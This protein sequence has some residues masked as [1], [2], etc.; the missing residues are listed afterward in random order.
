MTR[1]QATVRYQV[2]SAALAVFAACFPVPAA[3]Q[4][5]LDPT[6]FIVVG[7]GLGAGMADFALREVYQD[8]SFGAQMARQMKTAFPQPLIQSPGIGMTPGFNTLPV[9]LPGVLQGSVRSQFPPQLFVFNLSVP[10]MRLSDSLTRRPVPPV[11]QKDVFQTTLNMTLGY[12]ALIAGVNK[13]LWTQAEYAVKMN[14]SLVVVELG[15]Y[16]VLEP[17]I[18]N[19]PALLP[20]VATFRNNVTTL[21]GRLQFSSP[22]IV[23]MTIPDPFDTAYFANLAGVT[24]LTGVPASALMNIFNL[25]ADDLVTPSGIMAISNATVA[26]NTRNF[27][28]TQFTSLAASY[29]GSVVSAATRAA[30]Q[31]RLAALNT[32]LTTGASNVKAK[33]YDLAALYRGLRATGTLIGTKRITSDYLGGFFSLNGYYP[34]TTGHAMIANE[35][36][37]FLNKSYGT[38]FT[39]LDLTKI[40][41]DDPAVR[42]MPALQ[43]STE[44]IQ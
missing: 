12:P 38:S 37:S 44:D 43:I 36:L 19:D 39:L 41:P 34:G 13:P 10:G 3:A 40:L 4:T 15:F 33:V 30:V 5:K 23:V 26:T 2:F 20:D 24:R 31:A 42:F 32:E 7:E 22:E 6:Q 16:E 8:K 21:L 18:Q 28:G 27:L 14:P 17:A 9:R 29:P 25:K 11:V 35:L 1:T